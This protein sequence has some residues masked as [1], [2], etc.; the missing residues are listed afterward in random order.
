MSARPGRRRPRAA[1]SLIIAGVCRPL[2]A[3]RV[4]QMAAPPATHHQ[5]PGAQNGTVATE[6]A[7]EAV[8]RGASRRGAPEPAGPGPPEEEALRALQPDR[9]SNGSGAADRERPAPRLLRDP[10]TVL[11]LQRLAGHRAVARLLAES[12]GGGP[13]TQALPRS[14]VA[15]QRLETG[16]RPPGPG[17]A[18]PRHPGSPREAPWWRRRTL[19]PAPNLPMRCRRPV[20]A[21]VSR[22][23]W[24]LRER[25][26]PGPL[27]VVW[28]ALDHRVHRLPARC[29]G[30]PVTVCPRPQ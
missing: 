28:G 25:R 6:G 4:A 8:E 26:Q 17:W 10:R 5:R 30:P 15:V 7:R 22:A 27:L 21:P 13:R 29:R 18:V 2:R 23:R 9:P 1:D 11:A 14:P 16:R 19:P 3:G 12:A 20:A 24:A